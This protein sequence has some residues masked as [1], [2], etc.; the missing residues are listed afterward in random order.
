MQTLTEK[1]R[2]QTIEEF[3]GLDK[4]KRIAAKL[5]ADPFASA[6]LFIGEPGLGKTTLALAIAAAMPAELHH[7]PSQDCNLETLKTVIASCHYVP[8][9]GCRMHL[10]LVDEAD[11]MSSAAQNY[12]LSKLDSTAFPPDTIFIFTCNSKDGLEARFLS[13]CAPVEFSGYGNA[14]DAAALLEIIWESE[15][16]KGAETPNFARIVKEATGNVRASL[17]TLQN[18]LMLA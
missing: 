4:P 12:L 11:Q 2:P 9:L 6:Y 5:V 1:F 3:I 10:V 7:V 13:R 17:M 14:K 8:R 16:P 18:L 15:A